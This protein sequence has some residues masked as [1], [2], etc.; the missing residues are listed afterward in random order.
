MH[1]F[2]TMI[3]N[4]DLKPKSDNL[5]KYVKKIYNFTGISA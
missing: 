2:N 4:F 3:E 5:K 1:K